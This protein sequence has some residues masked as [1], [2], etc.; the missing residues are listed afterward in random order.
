M[1]IVIEDG[2]ALTIE[3]RRAGMAADPSDAIDGGGAPTELI[4][5][6]GE[7]AE[8]AEAAG[9][10]PAGESE[11]QDV[12]AGEAPLNPLRAGAEQARRGGRGA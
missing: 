3:S 2:D 8:L 5:E 12:E 10:A 9:E 6:F 11:P 1:R 4:R 7:G